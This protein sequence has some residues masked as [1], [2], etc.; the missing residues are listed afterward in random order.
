MTQFREGDVVICGTG[1][2]GTVISANSRDLGVLL[3]NG[4]I[5]YGSDGHCYHPDEE[6]LAAAPL[7]VDRFDVREK[8]P[9][10]KRR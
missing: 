8:A 6:T 1:Q 5:W 9:K 2:A 7:E 10:P 3:T 4:E